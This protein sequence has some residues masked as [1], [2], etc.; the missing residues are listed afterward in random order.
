MYFL[1]A[2]HE[3][4]VGIHTAVDP[5]QSH[6]DGIGSLQP[7]K[8][9]MSDSF[10]FIEEKSI[11]ALVHFADRGKMF[12]VIFIDGN[13]RF[14]DVLVDFTLSARLCP[15]GG[16]IVLDD[17]WMSPIR[18][19]VAFIRSNRQDFEELKTPPNIAAFRRI[20]EDARP[21]HH[22]VSFFGPSDVL[23]AIQ[24]GRASCRERV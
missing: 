4:G 8:V 3:S 15:M 23:R 14:D 20:S 7:K 17:L 19:V 11:P 18:R 2:I 16:C 24:I 22:Y 13:H 1:A 12:E 6:W 5:F 10:R 21:W 9:G